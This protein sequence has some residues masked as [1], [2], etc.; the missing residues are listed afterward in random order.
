[1]QDTVLYQNVTRCWPSRGKAEEE[2][3]KSSLQN[4]WRNPPAALSTGCGRVDPLSVAGLVFPPHG[5]VNSC[6][7]LRSE[8]S[9]RGSRACARKK[10]ETTHKH[11]GRKWRPQHGLAPNVEQMPSAR[12][13]LACR[14]ETLLSK[15]PQGRRSF[16]C[17]QR[18]R[19]PRRRRRRCP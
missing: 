18:Q 1:M 15:S 4:D 12:S 5:R 14:W 16:S 2:E 3:K 8:P 19:R 17:G 11:A 10:E 9:G 6:V 7:A 13:A